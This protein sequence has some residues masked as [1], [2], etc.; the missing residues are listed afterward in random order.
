M[1]I[2]IVNQKGGSGKTTTVSILAKALASIGKKI[3]VV[4]TDPQGGISS[5][6]LSKD[7][8]RKGLL[9]ILLEDE[10]VLGTNIHSSQESLFSGSID[11]IP[12]DYR[13]DKLFISCDPF[14][15]QDLLEATAKN[16]DYVLIDTPPTVQGIT[17]SAILFSDSVLIPCEISVQA[18]KPTLYT[19]DSVKNLKKN[20]KVVFIG[21]KEP[22]AG[23][24]GFQIN[25]T[26][27]F[28]KEFN[29]QVIGNL[30]KNNTTISFASETKKL[31]ASIKE[32]ITDKALELLEKLK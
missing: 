1:K 15:L 18:L 12:A 23:K 28:Q 24:N 5:V 14:A 7:D 22:Q 30:P 11:V 6:L 8:G 13:L 16:Y 31:T 32:N 29:G 20:S 17:K 21:F 3:L 27:T 9:E 2:A 10:I 26:R 19:M 25:L 4:D